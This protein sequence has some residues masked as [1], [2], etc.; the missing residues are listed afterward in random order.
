[1]K[2]MTTVPIHQD[3]LLAKF[4]D[5]IA[6]QLLWNKNDRLFLACSGGLDS[7]VLAHLLKSAGMPF[8]I[9]HCNFQLRGRKVVEMKSLF[10]YWHKS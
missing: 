9:L 8:T 7:V 3:N 6:D 2:K 1:M 10:N 4:Q 5:K